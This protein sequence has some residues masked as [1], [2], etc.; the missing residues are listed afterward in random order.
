MEKAKELIRKVIANNVD[1][2][3]FGDDKHNAPLRKANSLLSD[4]LLELSRFDW[5]SVE[6][7]L[8]DLNEPVIV[9]NKENPNDLWFSHRADSTKVITDKNGFANR[10]EIEEITHWHRIENLKTKN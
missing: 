2:L 8:P 7:E 1:S 9:C 6:K 4:A 5:I 3:E 10:M